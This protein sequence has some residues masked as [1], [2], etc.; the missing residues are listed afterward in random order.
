M[1]VESSFT[2]GLSLPGGAFINGAFHAAKSGK[3]FE[4]ITPYDGEVIANLPFLQM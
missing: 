4:T 3:T 2:K 1:N